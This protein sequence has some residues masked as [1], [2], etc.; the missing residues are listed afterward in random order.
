MKIERADIIHI[1][2]NLVSPFQ[3]SYGEDYEMDKIV[4]KV[5]TP[6]MIAYSE[7]VAEGYPYYAYETVGTVSEILRKFILPSV[8][9]I[10]LSGP[11]ECWEKISRFRGH[12]MA[13]A[14]VENAVWILKALEEGK[15]LGKLLGG[16]KDRVPAG[17]PIGIQDHVEKLIELIGLHL[18]KGYPRVKIK[19]KPGKDLDVVEAVRKQFPDITL[20][21]D[22]NNAYSLSD[23]KTLKA[24]DPY[25]LLMIEQPLAYDD[26]V[27]HAKL[28]SQMDTPICLD[29]SIHGPYYARI[30]AELNACRIINI[31]QGRVGGL[32]PAC[33]VHK[34][35]QDKGI[36]VWCGSMLEMGIGQAVNLAI[37]SLPNFVYP[38]DIHESEL[39][40]VKDL[41]DPP[42]TLNSDGTISVPSEP[43]LG[44]KVNEDVLE[45]FTV[46]REVIRSR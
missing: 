7:C 11:E 42:V 28:Q 2:M 46:G 39:F 40:W 25:R 10:H 19:I 14:A 36:G 5:Y 32:A 38:N 13:K 41:I 44:V 23:L 26:I 1:R 35:A 17:V 24:L 31:K 8:M 30:A 16:E 45:H 43:G 4:L 33:E 6:D 18:R 22:A 37:A 34:I 20:M 15:P 29:E 9:G 12:P 21:V 3:T 27:D